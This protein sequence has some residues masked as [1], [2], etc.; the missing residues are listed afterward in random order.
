MTDRKLLSG[1]LLNWTLIVV[2][3][4]SGAIVVATVVMNAAASR[5]ISAEAE[6]SLHIADMQSAVQAESEEAARFVSHLPDMDMADGADVGAGEPSHEHDAGTSAHVEGPDSGGDLSDHPEVLAAARKFRSA[7]VSARSFST[8][9]AESEAVDRALSA[10]DSYIEALKSLDA[11]AHSDANAMDTYHSGTQVTEAGLRASLQDLR[12]GAVEGLA[13]AVERAEWSQRLLTIMLPIAGAGALIAAVWLTR[14]RSTRRRVRFLERLISE[15]ERFIG[16]VSHELRTPLSAIVGFAQLLSSNEPELT[17]SEKREYHSHILTQGN[18][19]T[20]IVDDLL[21]AARA[22][23]G[24]LTMVEVPINLAAQARQVVETLPLPPDTPV[25]HDHDVT[26]YG[27]PVR[28]RQILRNLLTNALRY[29]GSDIRVEVGA[30]HDLAVLR[31]VDD[32]EPIGEEDRNRLF[33]PYTTLEGGRPVTGSIGLGLS[34]SRQLA[35][36]MDGDLRYIP[37]IG[38]SVFE[39]TLP[40]TDQEDHHQ[41]AD[42]SPTLAGA[43]GPNG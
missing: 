11:A 31:V 9:P 35:R 5:Q 42:S 38:Q 15:K 10:H 43:S 20:A 34:V 40:L 12:E 26:A 23:I 22:E 33:E 8:T 27:D 36:M 7:A 29:G 28:V 3:A 1:P 14:T 39:L 2:I 13:A 17:D 19:V 30:T 37:E 32:G 18:E 21:V 6:R 4:V 25:Q 16:T 24:E 41:D